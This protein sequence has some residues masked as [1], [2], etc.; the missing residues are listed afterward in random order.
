MLAFCVAASIAAGFLF[1]SSR[2]REVPVEGAYNLEEGKPQGADFSLF[3]E[4]WRT[5]QDKYVHSDKL[6]Y[7]RMTEGAI[8]G[9]VE[10]LEDPYTV[11]MD[12]EQTK[13]FSDDISG[14]F[15]GVGMEI[16]IKDKGLRVIAPLEG[17]PAQR[18]G[19][20]PGDAIVR[21]EEDST[22]GMS[23]E[24]AVA[25]IRGPKGTS[26]QMTI[27]RDGWSESREI[28]VE[29]A[30]IEIPSLALEMKEGNIAHLRLYQ[31]SQ[32]A[33]LDLRQ[34]ASEM[35]AMG[36]ERMIIDLRNN[37]GGYLEVAQDIAGWFLE[38][39]SPVVIERVGPEEEERV[40]E[41]QGNAAFVSMP[42]VVL[43]NEGSASAS[44][45]LAGA[46]RDNR[47]I[48]LIGEASFGKGSVQ[49]LRRLRDG[50][51]VKVTVAAWLT[52]GGTAIAEE[53]LDPDIPVPFDPAADSQ[54]DPQLERAIEVV[55]NL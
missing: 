24:E 16:G 22:F 10:S 34:A 42:V 5:L 18:A 51:S 32:K 1:G 46:L 23:L 50:S 36:A 17:T 20:K 33:P 29:R 44:E 8:R 49:E 9:M 15:E 4:A 37:P 52:P 38:S 35:R 11:F 28:Q 39:G 25:K 48:P 31:F 47:K 19:I 45:I 27:L 54:E 14:Y 26:V 12:R 7:G 13:Q 3:W 30:V 21:I 53:G 55:R 6:D 40:Y 43:I 41:A 2:A